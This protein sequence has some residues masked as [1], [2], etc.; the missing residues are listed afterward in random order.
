MGGK[1]SDKSAKRAAY[2][3]Y[4]ASKDQIRAAEKMFKADRKFAQ[5]EMEFQREMFKPLID[6]QSEA[7]GLQREAMDRQHEIASAQLGLQQTQLG[8]GQQDRDYYTGTFRPVEQQLVADARAFDTD[9]E[10]NRLATQAG[11]DSGRAFSQLQE[12]SARALA[13]RGVNPNSGAGLD[14]QRMMGI[15]QAAL[16]ANAMT[17]TRQQA[18][19]KGTA[20]RYAAVG[21]GNPLAAQA[22]NALTGA[23]QAGG[24]ASN[25]VSGATSAGSALVNA[26]TAAAGL[27]AAPGEFG[28]NA[29]N[30]TGGLYNQGVGIGMQGL[31][32]AAS[33]YANIYNTSA[34]QQG[35]MWGGIGSMLGMGLG[36][37]GAMR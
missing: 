11:A 23:T 29:R 22:Q 31:G 36:A 26:G 8:W 3:Q 9:A 12:M 24:V 7:I 16:R 21:L 30:Q 13:R 6:Q 5:K 25:A 19:D 14:Q 20:M 10:R 35:A 33:N 4:Q 28:L 1:S 32:N 17:G 27:I 2:A 34:Q 37:F 15:S 18:K